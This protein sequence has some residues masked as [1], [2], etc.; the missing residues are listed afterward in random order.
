MATTFEK[1]I[2]VLTDA[3]VEFVVIGGF[4]AILH[5][6]AHAT[7][8]LD[9]L[10]SR[11]TDN[12]ARLTRALAPYHPRPDGFPEGLPFLWEEATLRNGTVFTLKTDLG[13]IDLMTEV[14]GLGSF[15][16]IWEQ[17]VE[18]D[19]YGRRVRTLSLQDLIKAKRAAGRV[20]DL[21]VLPELESIQEALDQKRSG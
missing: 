6:S 14:S 13:R 9:I 7:L 2:H 4:S 8:D 3:G 20:K 12:F 16:E 21:Q 18:A 15:S 17:S 5:G 19:L 1:A 11:G 10:F